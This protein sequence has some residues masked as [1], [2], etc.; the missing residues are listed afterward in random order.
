VSRRCY[1]VGEVAMED[2]DVEVDRLEATG[3]GMTH[4]RSGFMAAHIEWGGASVRGRR[5]G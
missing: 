5:S 1:A 3:R 2:T 4:Q